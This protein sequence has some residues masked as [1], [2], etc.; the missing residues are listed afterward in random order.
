[1]RE[2]PNSTAENGFAGKQAGARVVGSN[3]EVSFG[4]DKAYSVRL[5][6][7]KDNG[8]EVSRVLSLLVLAMKN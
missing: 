7:G 6:L 3:A 1:M 4:I 5:R 8:A 2:R